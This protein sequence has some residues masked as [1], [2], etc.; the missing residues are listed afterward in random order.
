MKH[1]LEIS[2]VRLLFGERLI[3][4]D[5]YLKI[6]TGNIVGLLG[7]NG[8]GK[9][10]LM[11]GVYG[12]LTCEKSISIDD[13][14]FFDIYKQPHLMRYLPQ[15]YFIPKWLS[16][17][18]IFHDFR[19]DYTA[20]AQLFPE[21]QDR[22]KAKIKDLSGGMHRLVELYVI[23]KSDTQFILLDEPFTH[24]SPV[25]NDIIENIILSEA[26]NKGFLVTD[27]M[28]RRIRKICDPV[29]LLSNGKTHLVKEEEDL[30]ELRY[31]P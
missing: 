31:V 9:S 23:L 8:C 30:R 15:H 22:E 1:A 14:Y 20:F 26:G 28:Y 2:S 3:L 12:T 25:Y 24:I 5:V 4:S 13:I 21:F 18:R 19:V 29:Y 7:Q 11:R 17:K 10:C 6:E 27:H 16:L